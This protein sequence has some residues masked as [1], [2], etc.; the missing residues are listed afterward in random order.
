M[1]WHVF[2]FTEKQGHLH[3]ESFSFR[4]RIVRF[5]PFF[6]KHQSSIFTMKI[7]SLLPM[8]VCFV[9]AATLMVLQAQESTNTVAAAAESV[10][11]AVSAVPEGAVAEDEEVTWGRQWAAYIR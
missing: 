2:C 8:F 1:L 11:E 10:S 9:F 4:W 3:V 7:R 6:Q 5:R